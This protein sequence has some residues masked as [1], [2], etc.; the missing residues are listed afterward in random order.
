MALVAASTKLISGSFFP[1]KGVGT[2]MRYVSAAIGLSEA[3]S[4]PDL[5]ASATIVYNSGSTMWVFP[6]LMLSITR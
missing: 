5:T 3:V 4:L 6:A 2:T 1:L